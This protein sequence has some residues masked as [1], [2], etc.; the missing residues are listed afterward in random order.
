MGIHS[1]RRRN[2]TESL[3]LLVHD[4]YILE[5]KMGTYDYV[6]EM[7]FHGLFTKSVGLM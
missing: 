6:Y 5:L 1:K 7:N 2:D 3:I 4:I